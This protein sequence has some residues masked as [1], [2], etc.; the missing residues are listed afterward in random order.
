MFSRLQEPFLSLIGIS[1]FLRLESGIDH[2]SESLG[3]RHSPL[4]D[5]DHRVLP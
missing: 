3:A 5:Q 1:V 2:V 4:K